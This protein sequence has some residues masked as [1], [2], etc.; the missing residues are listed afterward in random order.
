[1]DI[2]RIK[3]YWDAYIYNE[4]E[5]ETVDVE[6]LRSVIGS[7][8]KRILEIACGAGRILVP[9]VK[10]GHDVTGFD[11]SEE[12]LSL[13]SDKLQGQKA[14]YY[15]ADAVTADWG[16]DFDVVVEAGN[17]MINIISDDDCAKTQQLFLSK[18]AGA[19]KPGGHLYLDFNFSINPA[20]LYNYDRERVVF[21]GYDDHGVHGV[22]SILSSVFHPETQM[23]SS[24]IETELTLSN[25]E[26]HTI[27]GTTTKHIPTL[28]QVHSWLHEAGFAIEQEYGDYQGNQISENT[29]RCVI[30]ARKE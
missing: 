29:C 22:Y 30:F 16:S 12:M 13:V 6:F 11:Y 8:P 20:R 10:D 24:E 1:M 2:L 9:L 14:T 28:D 5:N 4:Q 27:R 3:S 17:L 15:Q 26:K 21:K 23:L 7:A 18:A 25:G 19:L